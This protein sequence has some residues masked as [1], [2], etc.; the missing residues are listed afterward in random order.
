MKLQEAIN[1]AKDV[2]ERNRK[3]Y[4]NCPADRRDIENETCEMCAERHKQL[5]EWLEEFQK[6]RAIGTVEEIEHYVRLV[7][8]LN[9]CDLVR[10]N[11][12]LAKDIRFLE[13]YKKQL[14]EYKKIGTIEECREATERQRAKK[15]KKTQPCKSV[16]Y[17]QCPCCNSLLHM[18]ENFCGDCGQAISWENEE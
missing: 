12:R 1:H 16:N 10:E 17:Y 5:A 3:Q 15:Y 18:N 7:E 13:V 11:A 4:K 14:G 8:K 6:Y 9:L 2:A